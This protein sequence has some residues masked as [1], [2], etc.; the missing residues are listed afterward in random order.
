MDD[1]LEVI[2]QDIKYYFSLKKQGQERKGYRIPD[3]NSRY[4][5]DFLQAAE[6]CKSLEADPCEYVD[7]QFYNKDPD[8]IY[9]Q[10]LHS[11]Y[12][13][14]NYVKYKE[15]NLISLDALYQEYVNILRRQLVLGR[16]LDW[17]LSC[18]DLPFP[19]W[20][21]ICITK[22]PISSIVDS[23]KELAQQEMDDNLKSFL[24]KNNFDYKRITL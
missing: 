11:K 2:A 1:D 3:K 24:I 4:E 5:D 20:F 17:I 10:F 23:F 7:A 6:I 15:E 19:A 16:S 22:E 8:K 12:A 9:I 14:D 18:G 13:A 21:R